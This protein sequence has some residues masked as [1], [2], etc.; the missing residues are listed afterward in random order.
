[1]F[2][3]I[4]VQ[5]EFA[6]PEYLDCVIL[7]RYAVT[8]CRVPVTLNRCCVTPG[9]LCFSVDFFLFSLLLCRLAI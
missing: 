8:S 2:V 6:R 3:L 4:S 9:L 7:S 1:M 5:K